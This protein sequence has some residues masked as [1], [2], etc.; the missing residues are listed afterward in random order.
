MILTGIT[1]MASQLRMGSW[2]TVV[3]IV[4]ASAKSSLV[5]LFFMGLRYERPVLR[6]MFLVA[7]LSFMIFLG[8]T[9]VDY[10]TR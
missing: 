10:L 4:I 5:L 3:A 9:Y 8:L 1:V 7:I 2:S 6:W